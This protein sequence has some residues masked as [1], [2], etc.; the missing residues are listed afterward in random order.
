MEIIDMKLSPRTIEILKNYSTINQNI[1][2]TPGKEI[3]T[4]HP[5][6]NIVTVATI[7]D[8]F[9]KEA[10]IYDLGR[11]LSVYNLY[12]DPELKFG[13]KSIDISDGRAKTV[14]KL[15]PKNLLQFPPEGKLSI[16]GDVSGIQVTQ[17]DLDSVL[18]ASGALHLPDIA[19]IGANGKV[20]LQAMS[21]EDS[22]SDTF[23][24][25]IG[26]TEDEFKM[27]IKK[28]NF[29]FLSQDYEVTLSSN[30]AAQFTA[31]D[32][33]YVVAVDLNSTYTKK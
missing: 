11:F 25:D 26:E 5:Q 28:T 29:K 1:L 4:M 8:E 15:A 30:G 6:K 19:F 3:R 18:K 12:T 16:P 23:G 33:T 14:Y 9:P 2:I 17:K 32:I 20:R 24:I 31:S 13:D 10:P 7:E 22:G 21:I 27:F